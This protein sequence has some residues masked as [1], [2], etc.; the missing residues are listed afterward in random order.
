M[1]IRHLGRAIV[2]D[3]SETKN[4]HI[5][6]EGLSKVFGTGAGAMKALDNVDLTVRKGEFVSILG[7]S[8]CGKS[9]LLMILAGLVSSSS[10]TVAVS[11]NEVL[12]PLTDIG[13]V[14]QRDLLF[15]WRTILENVM[16][17]AD[18]RGLNRKASQE[19]AMLLL[20]TVG[21]KGFE[22]R[23]PW[24]LSGGMRQRVALCRALLHDASVLLLD[25]PFGALDAITRDQINLD[26]QAIWLREK[27]TSVLVTHSISEAIFLSDRVVVMS[28]RPG[29]IIYEVRIDLPRPRTVEMRDMPEFVGYQAKLR[30]SIMH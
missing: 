25:E 27:R 14:F 16:L 2:T 18:I 8:G 13:I 26:L 4:P 15:D 21:L 3:A 10:G 23:R 19:K 22:N 17:Q 28:T 12:R 29:R 30:D 5:E 6:V 20:E 24:E 9:T 1:N 7:P 11:G